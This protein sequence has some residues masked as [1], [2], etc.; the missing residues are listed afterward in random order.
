M[1][2][3]GCLFQL[4]KRPDWKQNNMC[5]IYHQKHEKEVQYDYL[6]G[7]SMTLQF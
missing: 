7:C 6:Q 4:E 2:G 3:E 1:C 5:D